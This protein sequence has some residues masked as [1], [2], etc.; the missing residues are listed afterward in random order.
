MQWH[1]IVRKL[2]SKKKKQQQNQT[3]TGALSCP[4]C[5]RKFGQ[6]ILKLKEF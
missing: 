5:R 4:S 1:L 6:N 3:L 2:Y